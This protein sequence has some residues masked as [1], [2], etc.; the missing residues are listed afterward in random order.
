MHPFLPPSIK[1]NGW[2]ADR[3]ERGRVGR[4]PAKR[5][6]FL[7]VLHIIR[8]FSKNRSPARLGPDQ[9]CKAWAQLCQILWIGPV[10]IR[11]KETF[12]G[13]AWVLHDGKEIDRLYL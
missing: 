11:K 2:G 6:F 13:L 4:F 1:P 9:G 3:G 7:L 10:L 12:L 5:G 8:C